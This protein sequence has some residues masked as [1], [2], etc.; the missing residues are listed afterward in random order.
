[1]GFIIMS[2]LF[3]LALTIAILA[4]IV[5]AKPKQSEAEQREQYNV[6]DNR[7]IALEKHIQQTKEEIDKKLDYQ[8]RCNDTA[9]NSVNTSLS[10]GLHPK[11]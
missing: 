6:L 3:S 4:T 5:D 2:K 1:M 9:I 8:M 7:I 11:T 10:G